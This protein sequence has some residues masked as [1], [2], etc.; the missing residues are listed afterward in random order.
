MIIPQTPASFDLEA[1]RQAK[2]RLNT[3]IQNNY[4]FSARTKSLSSFTT[5]AAYGKLADKLHNYDNSD[6]VNV[7][8]CLNPATSLNAAKLNDIQI[9]TD[10]YT[11]DAKTISGI[12]PKKVQVVKT[13]VTDAYKCF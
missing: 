11:R 6:L 13:G 10:Y 7:I 8:K 2:A 9:K 5:V 3:T 1:L 4:K 12:D